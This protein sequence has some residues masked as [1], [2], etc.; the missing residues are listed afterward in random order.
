MASVLE[1]D[2]EIKSQEDNIKG[3]DFS[4][5]PT[6]VTKMDSLVVDGVGF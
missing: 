5:N 3:A 6:L 1:K 2:E 4:K